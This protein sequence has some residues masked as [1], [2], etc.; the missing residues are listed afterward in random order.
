MSGLIEDFVEAALV[1]PGQAH[2]RHKKVLALLPKQFV[3][4]PQ[5]SPYQKAQSIIDF[6]AGMTDDYALNLYKNLRGIE[7]PGL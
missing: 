5:S 7:L 3:V 1:P 4:P 6:A 2:T